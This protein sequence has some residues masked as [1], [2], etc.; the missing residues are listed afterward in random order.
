MRRL[1]VAAVMATSL[2]G[3]FHVRYTNDGPPTADPAEKGWHHNV[4]FGLVEVSQPENASKACPDG[5]A[6]VKSEQS[7]VAGLVNVLT[8]SHYNPTDFEISSKAKK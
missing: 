2:T 7:F 1:L 6:L 3:C 5:F 4:V 8:L